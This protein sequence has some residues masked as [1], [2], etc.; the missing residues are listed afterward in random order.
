[1]HLLSI[2]D[3]YWY[4]AEIW[5]RKE[6]NKFEGDV[7]LQWCSMLIFFPWL[8]MIGHYT[9]WLITLLL[10]ICVS[11]GPLVFCKMRYTQKRKEEL[12]KDYKNIKCEG[13]LLL[14]IILLTAMFSCIEIMLM[15][16]LEF[17]NFK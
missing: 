7:L 14:K 2:I 11:G 10:S 17:M 5:S 15:F 1:M 8:A 16:Y 12:S 3:N 9:N 4:V 13:K 6:G